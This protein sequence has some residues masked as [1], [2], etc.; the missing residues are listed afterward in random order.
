MRL[1]DFNTMSTCLELLYAKRLGNHLQSTFIFTF[2]VQLFLKR[3]FFSTWSHQIWIIFN[4]SIWL[5]EVTQTG[6]T[7]PDQNNGHEG[8]NPHSQSLQNWSLT[9]RC[10]LVSYPKH[11]FLGGVLPFYRGYSQHILSPVNRAIC[12]MRLR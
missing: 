5:I 9:I 2:F 1:I 10:S 12:A 4:R 11:P 8:M 6:T 7:I 3:V